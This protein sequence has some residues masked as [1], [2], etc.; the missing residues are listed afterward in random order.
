MYRS[1]A[2]CVSRFRPGRWGGWV[3]TARS[4]RA[5]RDLFWLLPRRHPREPSRSI[6]H[7]VARL[8]Q[9]RQNPCRSKG[10]NVYLSG[11]AEGIRTPDPLTASP[12]SPIP[13]D[14]A[15]SLAIAEPLVSVGFSSRC[16][17]T[18]LGVCSVVS[19][20]IGAALIDVQRTNRR[21][22]PSSQ[23]TSSWVAL[24]HRV[25][26]SEPT[27]P[28]KSQSSSLGS[29]YLSVSDLA[30]SAAVCSK[31][32]SMESISLVES[33]VCLAAVRHRLTVRST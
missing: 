1:P 4:P 25:E 11:G 28:E 22:A 5:T 29:R 30:S 20:L 24:P 19:G 10:F 9:I 14:P 18:R 13:S 3:P 12:R 27:P 31:A 32:G 17:P 6:H 16:V 21:C 23:L 7:R 26:P 15:L 2:R 33:P 8:C